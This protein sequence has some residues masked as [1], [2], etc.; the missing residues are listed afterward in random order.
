MQVAYN[1]GTFSKPEPFTQEKMDKALKNSNVKH[2][3]VFDPT[4]ENLEYR[5]KFLGVRKT[6]YKGKRK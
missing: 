6:N 2:V 1:D 5:K 3:E 4:P